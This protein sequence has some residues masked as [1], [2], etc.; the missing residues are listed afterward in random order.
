M[1]EDAVTGIRSSMWATVCGGLVIVALVPG[2]VLARQG[3]GTGTGDE[4]RVAPEARPADETEERWWTPLLESVRWLQARGIHPEAGVI[5]AGSGLSAGAAYRPPR[6]GRSRWGAEADALWS[7]RGYERLRLRAGWIEDLRNRF[8]LKPADATIAS[9]FNDVS[10]RDPGVSIYLDAQRRDY[11]QVNFY[12]VGPD[13][14]LEA[15]SDY[16]LSGTTVDVVVQWQRNEHLGVSGRVGVLDFDIG[17][18]SN[19][20]VP[21]LQDQFDP[22][23]IPGALTSPR[24]TTAGVAAV[25]DTRDVPALPSS[26]TFLGVSVWRFAGTPRFTRFTLD[27]RAFVAPV[28]ERSV[29]AARLLIGV[30]L[31]PDR[32]TVPFFLQ[33]YL[34]GSETLR[35]YPSYRLRDA[36]LL[37][38]SLEYRWRAFRR[39]EIAP[40]VDV[41]GVGPSLADLRARTFDVTP[42][43]GFR[44]RT[45][46]RPLFRLDIARRTDGYRLSF[47]LSQPF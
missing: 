27:G 7:V 37:H 39:L 6:I 22:T 10:A 34:G 13:V 30:D 8:E 42:G 17:R 4:T 14:S 33:R 36:A 9:Q 21:D 15:K 41:G 23:T 18:G 38:L 19:D 12:G 31:V 1:I 32:A 2:P 26:G 20:G 47:S 5:V 45:D 24:Y 40:F 11:P 16:R 25:R 35:G 46:K 29:L 3:T 28:D 43:I 44:L